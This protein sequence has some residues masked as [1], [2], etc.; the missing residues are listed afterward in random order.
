MHAASGTWSEDCSIGT[1]AVHVRAIST[2]S[3]RRFKADDVAKMRDI[4]T[5]ASAAGVAVAFG[6]PIGGVLF[7]I[8]EMNQGFSTRTMWQSFVC[9]LVA[10]FTLAVSWHPAAVACVS[11]IELIDLTV[12]GPFQDRQTRPL[13][14]IIRPGLALLR[15][16]SVS[17]DRRFR[18][19]A[20]SP[21]NPCDS[22]SSQYQG[23]YGVFVIKFNLQVAAFRRKNLKEHGVAEAVS[24]AVLTAVIGYLNRFL[25]IDMTECMEILFKEC[26]GGGDKHGLCQCVL[27]VFLCQWTPRVWLTIRTSAQW[28]MINSLLLATIVRTVL[29][30]ISYGCKVPCGIFVPSMAVGAMFGRMIGILMK[31]LHTSITIHLLAVRE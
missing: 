19:M 7:S 13:Y 22:P 1:T 4:V 21:A 20:C 25:R 6:S 31:A 18:C 9:A 10:T 11:V 30:I 2:K 23:L 29:V 14:C 8:E 17:P 27:R 12:Y 3:S 5:S 15:D 16:T 24:L 26:E 28:R